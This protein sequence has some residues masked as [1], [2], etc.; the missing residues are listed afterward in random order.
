MICSF[1]NNDIP[2]GTGKIYIKNDGKVLNFCSRRCEKN[3]LKLR[4]NPKTTRWVKK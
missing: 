1:C 2:Q 3:L 4:R